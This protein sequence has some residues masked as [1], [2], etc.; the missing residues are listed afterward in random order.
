MLGVLGA[1]GS[2]GLSAGGAPFGSVF[3]GLCTYFDR[4]LAMWCYSSVMLGLV[5]DGIETRKFDAKEAE[6]TAAE[7][8]DKF[9]MHNAGK[10]LA[11]AL[12]GGFVAGVLEDTAGA[13][14]SGAGAGAKTTTAAAGGVSYADPVPTKLSKAIEDAL[15]AA[16]RE[17][18]K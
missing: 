6:K 2:A 9:D 8:C 5:S 17:A 3:S 7:L 18:R 11:A 13:L 15:T 14:L 10:S 4:I 16:E 12:T 1:L